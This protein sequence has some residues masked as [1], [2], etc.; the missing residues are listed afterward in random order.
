MAMDRWIEAPFPTNVRFVLYACCRQLLLRL[1]CS[2]CN[3]HTHTASPVLSSAHRFVAQNTFVRL[4]CCASFLVSRERVT[5]RPLAMYR[6]LYDWLL[7]TV[8]VDCGHHG[9]PAL[10]GS[11]LSVFLQWLPDQTSGRYLEWTWH[12]LFGELWIGT[13]PEP[14]ILCPHRPEACTITHFR[15]A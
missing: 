12:V 11:P 6:S 8:C 10:I 15:R 1:A 13:I 7:I 9:M 2:R 3:R 14:H 5:A 4:V